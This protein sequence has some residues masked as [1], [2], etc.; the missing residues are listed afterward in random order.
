MALT[1]EQILLEYSKCMKNTPYAFKTYLQT[2]DQTVLRYVPLELFED[3]ITLLDDYENYSENITL[4]YRQGGATTITSAWLSKKLVFAKKEKPEKVLIMANKQE[5]AIEMANKVR[6]FI[7]F[8]PSWV[9]IGFAKEKNSQKHFKLT[10]DCEVKAVATSKDSLRGY[11]PTILIIDEAS[12]IETDSDFWSAAMASLSTGGKVIVISTPNGY[13]TIYYPIY[14]Q[15]L[16]GMNNFKITELYWYRDPRYIKDLYL[17][18]CEDIV[19]YLLN[20][21]E[22]PD[23]VVLEYFKFADNQ[24]SNE[25]LK[26]YF[27]KGYKPCSSWF[28]MMVKKLKYDRRKISQELECNFLGSGDNVFDSKLL[29]TITDNLIL[30]PIE[31]LMGSSLWIWQRPIKGH[32]YILGADVSRGDSEDFSTIQIVDFDTQ[33]QVLE[34][35]GK[36]PPDILA[37]IVNKWGITYSAFVVVDATGLGV[38]TSVKLRELGYKNVYTEGVNY[39][40]KWSYDP[41]AQDKVPGLNFSGK[42]IQIVASFEE[43]LRHDFKIRST[44]LLNEMKTFIYINGKPDHQKG[45]HDDLIMSISVALYVAENSFSKLTRAT[46]NAKAMLESWTVASA[47][48]PTRTQFL[49]PSLPD[50]FYGNTQV[51]NAPSRQDYE[52]YAWLFGP[53]KQ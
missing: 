40:D 26:Q 36:L 21:E 42:R 41:R 47:Q 46:E 44:R 50:S 2:Y 7:E 34:Y 45:H 6:A 19:H 8:W 17:V 30:E 37:E 35:V 1:K 33:E 25:V 38:S 14:D 49:N 31:K 11:T 20:K 27:A 18:K 13:D 4:K 5:T 43:A 12:H 3:Q 48:P 9:G 53:A 24:K 39:M 22:Y 52:K 23:E 15:S 51:T 29:Q 32:R 28:E 10:N 16:R